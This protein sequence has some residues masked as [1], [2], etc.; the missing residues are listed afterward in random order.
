M[1]SDAIVMMVVGCGLLWGGFAASVGFA[2]RHRK[3]APLRQ[4]SQNR[5]E[6]QDR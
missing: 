6:R 1:S 4:E 5:K 2:I 3:A